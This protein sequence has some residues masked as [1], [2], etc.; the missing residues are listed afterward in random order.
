METRQKSA[1]KN[2]ISLC[3]PLSKLQRLR[4]IVIDGIHASPLTFLSR[5][6]NNS[7]SSRSTP[8]F[9]RLCLWARKLGQVRPISPNDTSDV[10]QSRRRSAF[11]KLIADMKIAVIPRMLQASSMRPIVRAATSLHSSGF[12]TRRFHAQ[13]NDGEFGSSPPASRFSTSPFR[14]LLC[15][16]PEPSCSPS[17]SR[18][19]GGSY[20]ALMIRTCRHRG[21]LAPLVSSYRRNHRSVLLLARPCPNQPR[22]DR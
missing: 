4:H 10:T 8:T 1:I 19:A 7:P 5:L 17:F 3:F 2:R 15:I 20:Q 6:D 9:T 12:P 14:V 18:S 11:R 22:A 13:T 16:L 21:E